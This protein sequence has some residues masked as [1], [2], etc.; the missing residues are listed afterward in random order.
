MNSK[1]LNAFFLV[2]FEQKKISNKLT[3]VF[4]ANRSTGNEQKFDLF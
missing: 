3:K 1:L 2:F 4:K